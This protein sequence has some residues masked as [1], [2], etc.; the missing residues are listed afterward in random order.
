M[1]SPTI[2]DRLSAIESQLNLIEALI[3]EILRK[4]EESSA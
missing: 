3:G 4:M 2:P 1:K